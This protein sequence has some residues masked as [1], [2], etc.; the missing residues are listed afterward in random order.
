MNGFWF[1]D[2]LHIFDKRAV[3][4]HCDKRK[5]RWQCPI[6][7]G[8]GQLIAKNI[9]RYSY[10]KGHFLRNRISFFSHLIIH[11]AYLL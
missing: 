9:G 11:L 2:I 7:R 4:R 8:I 5:L 3:H 1:G 10:A 6:F